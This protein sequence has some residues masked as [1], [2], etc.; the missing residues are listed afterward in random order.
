[1]SIA[2][3]VLGFNV[4]VCLFGVTGFDDHNDTHKLT[5]S[6]VLFCSFFLFFL[7]GAE[8]KFALSGESVEGVQAP[9]S[10]NAP[11]E[12]RLFVLEGNG[13][14]YELMR[15]A[16]VEEYRRGLRVLQARTEK[17][18]SSSTSTSSTSAVYLMPMAVPRIGITAK[19]EEDTTK[20]DWGGRN[21]STQP[22]APQQREREE[23]EGHVHVVSCNLTAMKS[24]LFRA[25]GLDRGQEPILPLTLKERA[26]PVLEQRR[27]ILVRQMVEIEPQS[28]KA[29][30]S[31]EQ[32]EKLC[33]MW[34]DDRDSN[35]DRFDVDDPRPRAAIEAERSLSA[36]ILASRQ[37]GTEDGEISSN[38]P[39]S[40]AAMR[41]S[42]RSNKQSERKAN[43]M[44]V[45]DGSSTNDPDTVTANHNKE[46]PRAEEVEIG[47]GEKQFPGSNSGVEEEM[48][49][50][51]GEDN[52]TNGINDEHVQTGAVDENPV[53]ESRGS[54][55]LY[56]KAPLPERTNLMRYTSSSH[57]GN[58]L[59]LSADV[60][61][62]QSMGGFWRDQN[63][64]IS[65]PTSKQVGETTSTSKLDDDTIQAVLDRD[66]NIDHL[67]PSKT[68]GKQ[69][70]SNTLL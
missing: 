26:K 52:P 48:M 21:L 66:D 53:V 30:R 59:G 38:R 33:A 4:C 36:A 28:V 44:Q 39:E 27:A 64:D 29:I 35:Q 5:Y 10:I 45:E 61:S 17:T 67:I 2:A 19:K 34:R 54:E 68:T 47:E 32:A 22:T 69:T 41:K 40:R 20:G 7:L 1:M 6:F 31:V 8:I 9:A 43:E 18:I 49:P 12:P 65:A 15:D 25:Q 56:P 13:N 63:P 57:A 46:E 51:Q 70:V 23:P 16:D 55:V 50:F 14:G 11:I 42:R 3:L 62:A 60:K 58:V 24:A 37:V